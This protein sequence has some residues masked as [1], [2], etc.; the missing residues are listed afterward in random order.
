MTSLISQGQF[1]VILVVVII[2]LSL[3]FVGEKAV[4]TCFASHSHFGVLVKRGY[5]QEIHRIEDKAEHN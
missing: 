2:A 1:Q 4:Y 3:P 5:G